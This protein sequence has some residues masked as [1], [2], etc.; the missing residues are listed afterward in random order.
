MPRRGTTNTPVYVVEQHHDVLLQHGPRRDAVHLVHFDSHPDMQLM[1][2]GGSM[3]G[4]IF[5]DAMS[6][7]RLHGL[8]TIC[9]WITPLLLSGRITHVWWIC[10][11]FCTQ[12]EPGEYKLCVGLDR[13]NGKMKMAPQMGANFGTYDCRHYFGALNGWTTRDRL[14]VSREW[15]LDVC[16]LSNCGTMKPEQLHRLVRCIAASS[17]WLDVDEDFL[18]C[19]NPDFQLLQ[20]LLGPDTAQ[21]IQQVYS[22]LYTDAEVAQ[23]WQ[24]LKR[25]QCLQTETPAPM[26]QHRK[27]WEKLRATLLEYY[28]E[29]G[30]HPKPSDFL[31]IQELHHAAMQCNLPHHVSSVQEIVKLIQTLEHVVSDVRTQPC[32][33]TVARSSRDGFVPPPHS[34]HIHKVVLSTLRRCLQRS[35]R[36]GRKTLART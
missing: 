19:T 10:A 7:T 20:N 6:P 16:R 21:I 13:G 2:R 27:L 22:N 17:W 5:R 33:V 9:D 35:R 24:C 23:M 4:E 25:R 29:K 1:S 30:A 12:I 11:S 3:H 14:I 32:I 31:S 36:A 18:T 28:K 34:D 15:T 8:S 26:M